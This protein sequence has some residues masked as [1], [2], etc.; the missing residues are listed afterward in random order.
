[1]CKYMITYHFSFDYV[2]IDFSSLALLLLFN[3]TINADSDNVT[4]STVNLIET[5]TVIIPDH[6]TSKGNKLTV[7]LNSLIFSSSVK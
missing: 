1:M 6:T 4:N 7:G 5:S 2:L 3:I